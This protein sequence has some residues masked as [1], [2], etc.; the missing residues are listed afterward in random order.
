MV[1]LD[2]EDR[3]TLELVASDGEDVVLDGRAI[4]RLDRMGLV[5]FH[6]GGWT[7]TRAGRL[8]RSPR[9]AEATHLQG[10]DV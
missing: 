2:L 1:D 5:T 10:L 4:E 6:R 8:S 3:M 9:D 7:L